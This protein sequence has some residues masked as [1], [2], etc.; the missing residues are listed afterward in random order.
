MSSNKDHKYLSAFNRI[1]M[2]YGSPIKAGLPYMPS[3]LHRF[4]CLPEVCP[5]TDGMNDWEDSL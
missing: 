1:K 2:D 3:E 4:A 5:F